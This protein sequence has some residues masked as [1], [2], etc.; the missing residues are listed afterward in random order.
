MPTSLPPSD[1]EL[2]VRAKHAD[3]QA[4]ALLY[5]RYAPLIYRYIYFRV[6][7]HEQA[8]DLC[9]DVFVR[10]LEGMPRY[11]DRGWPISA[12]LYRIARDRLAD[13][14]RNY[15]RRP[16]APLE[17]WAATYDGPEQSVPNALLCQDLVRLFSALTPEQRQVLTMRF[18]ENLPTQEVARRLGRSEGAVK[19][20]Q[21]RALQA[22]AR[23]LGP[24]LSA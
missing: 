3:H 22:L 4:L 11:E 23:H 7:Q 15:K 10:M 17:L 14:A 8:E 19:A 16:Q 2:I 24:A 20:M 5:E 21:Y 18:A 9:A 13:T 1:A 6:R 12:W